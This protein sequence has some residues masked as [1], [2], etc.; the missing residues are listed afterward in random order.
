MEEVS[1]V[2][3]EKAA[4]K[5]LNPVSVRRTSVDDMT[6]VVSNKEASSTL[7]WFAIYLSLPCSTAKYVS[8]TPP[9]QTWL[10]S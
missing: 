10:V 8:I 3:E 9:P 4:K 6:G 7:A 1:E 2:I 5:V